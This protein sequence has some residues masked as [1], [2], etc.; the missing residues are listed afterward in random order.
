MLNKH[1][2]DLK[3]EFDVLQNQFGIDIL[4]MR[5]NKYIRCKCYDTLHQCGDPKCP[6]CFGMGHVTSIEKRRTILYNG[7]SSSDANSIK[8]S[9]TGLLH[10]TG[11]VLYTKEE[12]LSKE[13]DFIFITTWDSMGF[14]VQILKVF[15]IVNAQPVRDTKGKTA[16]CANYT[17]LRTDMTLTANK[18][19]N[20]LGS[21]AKLLLS[22]GKRYL[23]PITV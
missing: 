17:K 7:S 20:S 18:Y 6:T 13:R 2:I 12:V 11:N 1:D 4:Y 15:E 9:E 5:A 8:P 14:P 22:K 10:S 21:N 16:F 3:K 23:W 19:V